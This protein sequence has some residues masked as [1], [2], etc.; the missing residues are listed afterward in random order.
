MKYKELVAGIADC[1]AID[2]GGKKYAGSYLAMIVAL[3]PNLPTQE[4]ADT[5]QMI[6]E[7]GT[8]VAIAYRAKQE[9]EVGYRVWRDGTVHRL[10]NSM[11]EATTAGFRCITDPGADAKGNPKPAKMPATSAVEAYMRTLPEYVE[12]HKNM[13]VTEEAWATIHTTLEAARQRT[14]AIRIFAETGTGAEQA[15]SVD[16]LGAFGDNSNDSDIRRSVGIE[17]NEGRTVRRPPPPP[18]VRR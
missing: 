14:W 16:V 10:T 11:A 1:K 7:L 17:T 3:N 5:P 12:H 18:L 13:M 15:G 4:A 9:A 8:L 6:S 2:I